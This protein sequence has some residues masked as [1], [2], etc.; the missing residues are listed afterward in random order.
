LATTIAWRVD[1]VSTYALEGNITVTGS[2]VDWLGGVLARPGGASDIAALA[3][4]VSDTGGVYVVPAFA[5]LGA[6]Y[7]D[8]DARGIVCGLTRGT[9]AAHI[10]RA[11]IESIA[12]QVADVF[13]AM[14]TDSSRAAALLADGG[15]SRNDSLMQFQADILGVPVIRR[16]AA[17]VSACGTAWLAGRAVGLW[18]AAALRAI[19]RAV[20]RFEPRMSASTRAAKRDGW[21]SAIAM[22]CARQKGGREW[23]GSTSSD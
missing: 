5:G 11:T 6:P 10:A 21:A 13:E 19:P 2:A 14:A 4:A 12:F 15:A 17:D 16:D 22:A 18:D 20:S 1:G 7:W 8:A 9:T 23:R 3:D